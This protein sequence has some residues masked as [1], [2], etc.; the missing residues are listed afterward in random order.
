MAK[1][2]ISKSENMLGSRFLDNAR[3]SIGRASGNDIQ[4]DDAAVSKQ[5]AV[6]EIV[7]KDHILVDMGSS[8][9]TY[10]NGGRVARH[11]LR[12]G[13]VIEVRDFQLR[14]VDHKSVVTGEGDR[15]MVVARSEL[16][17]PPQIGNSPP[18]LTNSAPASA[19]RATKVNFAQ[20]SIRVMAGGVIGREI[21]L[22]R[23]LM[24]IGKPGA[25]RAA[26]FR[27]TNGFFV[28][29]VD[30][31]PPKVNGKPISPGWQLLSNRDFIQVGEETVQIWIGKKA[32]AA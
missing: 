30:G 10:V 25:A 13:D 5:H 21:Q 9:G 17:P 8:N 23:P 14:Y 24:P 2:V 3:I 20:G 32:E 11:M 15:T 28:A 12:H 26:I 6:I 27:R 18:G 7:G 1:L 19:A 22:D 4:L 29:R 31:H 16:T